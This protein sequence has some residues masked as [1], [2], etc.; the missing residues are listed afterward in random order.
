MSMS[1][2]N[3]R[4]VIS[5]DGTDFC[6]WQIQASERT[7]Q[8]VLEEA[9][10]RLLGRETRVI[11][12]G[13]TDSGV[14]ANGQVVNFS[15]ESS[16]PTERFRHAVNSRLPRDVRVVS[17]DEVSPGFHARF[18]A[19]LRTYKY[20]IRPAEFADPIG[21]RFE[22]TIKRPLNLE[23]LNAF[24]GHVVGT[25]DFT[26][27]AAAGDQSD[28]KV[29]KIRTAVF[30]REGE[31]LVFRID[32]NAFLWKMVRSLVGSILEYDSEGRSPTYM[33]AVIAARNRKPAGTTAPAK[34]LFLHRV[35]YDE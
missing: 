5:Y 4:L 2:R 3:I 14:H 32:G 26:A 18:S 30:Y 1:R 21:R 33:A 16:I 23:R 27:F 19:R 8:G 25:H 24:A 13:R 20:Y 11:V 10:R 15:C 28:S 17:S 9:L 12:A 6:G 22:L 34:G 29:R 7:V 35:Q 31:R